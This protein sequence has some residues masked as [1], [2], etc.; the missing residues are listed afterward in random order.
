MNLAQSPDEVFDVVDDH[1]HVI[2][3]ATRAEVHALNLQHRAVH[4]FVYRPDGSVLLQK[5]SLQKDTSPGKWTSSCSGHVDS[6]ESYD[7]AAIRELKEEVGILIT[8]PQNVHFVSKHAPC[9]LTGN[10]FVQLYRTTTDATPV[11]NLAEVADLVWM[12]PEEVSQLL[13][14]EPSSFSPAFALVWQWINA[15]TVNS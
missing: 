12:Q 1:D 5:R 11:G 7:T 2:R 13:Q 15:P 10:E 9:Q 8:S 4:I 3:Q 14:D 6:G